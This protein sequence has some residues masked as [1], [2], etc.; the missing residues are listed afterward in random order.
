MS[1]KLS[2]LIVGAIASLA[3]LAGTMQ[4]CGSSSSSNNYTALCEQSCDKAAM[5]FPDSGITAT[6]CKQQLCTSQTGTT[7]CS[8]ASAIATAYQRCL[9]MDCAAF[10]SCIENDIPDCQ[11]TTGTGGT[12]GGG[13]TSGSGGSS[14]GGCANCTKFDSCCI[15]LGGDTS[16]CTLG[17]MCTAAAATSQASYNSGCA[18][19][20]TQAA[21]DP[22]APAA[23]R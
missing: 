17:T 8:N 4:G 10:Q 6:Q 21:M 12:S 19:A 14:G 3:L 11:T 13:G 23:C 15:A 5:C 18:T 1:R 9:S 16:S 2:A 7:T 22:S 20:L